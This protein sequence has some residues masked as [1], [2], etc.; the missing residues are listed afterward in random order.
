ME[1]AFYPK[2][3]KKP[4]NILN[5]VPSKEKER[6]I[7]V[8]QLNKHNHNKSNSKKMFKNKNKSNHNPQY[9]KFIRANNHKMQK[10]VKTQPL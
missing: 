5:L 2:A 6:E 9:N 4:D 3:F 1:S 10:W 8:K 7:Q